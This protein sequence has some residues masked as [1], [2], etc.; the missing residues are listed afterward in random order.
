MGHTAGLGKGFAILALIVFGTVALVGGVAF[1]IASIFHNPLIT[2]LLG[3]AA[4]LGMSYL[5]YQTRR[6]CLLT[7]LSGALGGLIASWTASAIG[8]LVGT[9]AGVIAGA[10]ATFVAIFLLLAKFTGKKDSP[11]WRQ[12][13][14]PLEAPASS[15]QA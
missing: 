4:A 8:G 10:V 9:G 1:G 11:A 3:A 12:K 14:R 7:G 6:T 13:R 2:V 5:F 15:G